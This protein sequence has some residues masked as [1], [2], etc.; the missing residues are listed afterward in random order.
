MSPNLSDNILVTHKLFANFNKRKGRTGS[1]A[2]KLDLEKAY[3]FLHWN[4][5]KTKSC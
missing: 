5:I 3:D 4:Y 1:M 2:I